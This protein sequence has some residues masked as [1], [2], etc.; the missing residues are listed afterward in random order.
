MMMKIQVPT[1]NYSNCNNNFFTEND[2]NLSRHKQDTNI[3]VPSLVK[4]KVFK[5]CQMI[6]L[7]EDYE[8]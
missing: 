5:K 8:L 6:D 1:N 7:P 4:V 2:V 3:C